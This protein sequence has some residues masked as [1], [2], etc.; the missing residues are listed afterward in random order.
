MSK[1]AIRL[2]IGINLCA[3]LCAGN[4]YSQ[5][6]TEAA[7][8]LEKIFVE[9]CRERLVGNYDKAV[10]LLE[11]L[12]KKDNKNHAAM[13]ELAR[14]YDAQGKY[15]QAERLLQTAIPLSPENDWYKKFLADVYQKGGK[16]P[17]AAA[18]YEQLVK[19]EPR[20]EQYYFKWAYL[21]VKADAIDR[22]IKAYDELERN[23]GISEETVRRKHALYLGQGNNKK[24]AEELQ[25]LI[26]AFPKRVDYRHLLAGFYEQTGDKAKALEEYRQI[27]TVAPND[28]KAQLALAGGRNAA[29]DDIAYLQSLKPAFE[30]PGAS[31]DLKIGKMI[32]LIQKV[33]NT[34]NAALADAALELTA[35]L[36][37][38][39]PGEAKPLAAAG[40]LLYY[41]GRHKEAFA[42][43]QR[44][45]EL[46]KAVFAVWEQV[47]RIRYESGQYA[48]LLKVSEDALDYFPNRALAYYFN[49]AALIE[50]GKIDEAGRV[51]EQAMLMTGNDKAIAALFIALKGALAHARKDSG[52][53]AIYFDEALQLDPHSAYVI[54]NH[55]YYLCQRN[56][57]AVKAMEMAQKADKLQPG[58]ARTQ[59]TL[60]WLMLKNKDYTGA[61]EHLSKA[62]QINEEEDPLLLEHYGDALYQTGDTNGALAYWT[63]AQAKGGRSA[64]LDRKIAEKKWVE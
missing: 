8:S 18:I 30:N 57:Q 29:G 64:V 33:A 48:A 11:D 35:V 7:A 38:V 42:K 47:M 31:I 60:G 55:S 41:T 59:H 54:S 45:L 51:I 10:P 62:L 43:Y 28:S 3:A 14:V 26:V 27:L 24:A 15:E 39:H 56:E 4:A 36:E 58:M 49:A 25:R 63:K 6:I 13:Y 40:D 2:I 34:G 61:R 52:K 12:L 19:K 21:L 32:P 22:A 16:F 17:A 50:L 1:T 37:K 44:A 23:N 53:F 5:Q 20:N 46:D 9:A